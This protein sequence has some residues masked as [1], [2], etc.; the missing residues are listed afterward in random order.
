[1]TC[2]RRRRHDCCFSE[3]RVVRMFSNRTSKLFRCLFRLSF[4]F[5]E[6]TD[7]GQRDLCVCVCRRFVARSLSHF[8]VGVTID[9]LC[10]NSPK[11]EPVVV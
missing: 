8:L 1:M 3:L 5:C 2:R 6:C 10:V 7:E 4:S 11:R 9:R